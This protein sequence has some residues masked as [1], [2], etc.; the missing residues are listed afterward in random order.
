MAWSTRHSVRKVY[1]QRV[2]SGGLIIAC[3]R[4]ET[5]LFPDQLVLAVEEA[6]DPLDLPFIQH[7]RYLWTRS[8]PKFG[9]NR[10]QA[11]DE[12]VETVRLV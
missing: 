4:F 5:D 8:R 2:S 9:V 3:L 10:R 7:C 11:M 6:H 1:R 12:H